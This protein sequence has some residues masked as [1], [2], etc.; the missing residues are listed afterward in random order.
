MDVINKP[1]VSYTKK[2]LQF[3][4]ND[5]RKV[6]SAIMVISLPLLNN[7]WRLFPADAVDESYGTLPVFVWM[8][9]IHLMILAI[10]LAWYFSIPQ[11]DNVLRFIALSIVAYGVLLTLQVFE[12]TKGTPLWIDVSA[13]L[14]IFAVLYFCLQYIQKNYLDKPNDYKALHD[15]LVYDIH[16]QRF[17]GSIDR[18]EGIID[19]AEMDEPYRCYCAKEIEELKESIAYIAEKYEALN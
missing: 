13:S 1:K 12:F 2:S 7:F 6:L 19:M 17:M 16:H 8:V 5:W 14:T 9:C 18:I 15:G 11:K 4:F 10:G 3:F